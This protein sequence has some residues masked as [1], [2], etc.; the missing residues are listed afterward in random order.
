MEEWSGRF[1]P[2]VRAEVSFERPHT[3]SDPR[4]LHFLAKSTTGRVVWRLRV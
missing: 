1:V 2:T 4:I 3:T